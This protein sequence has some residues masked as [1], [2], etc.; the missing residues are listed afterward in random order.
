[1]TRW[2]IY[3][4]ADRREARELRDRLR[5]AGHETLGLRSAAGR[6]VLARPREPDGEPGKPDGEPGRE[7][8]A[9]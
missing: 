9:P 4:V 5:R 1:M 6:V 8:G 2:L 7:S 3:R